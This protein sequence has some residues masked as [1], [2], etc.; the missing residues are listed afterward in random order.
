M[1]IFNIT[2]LCTLFTQRIDVFRWFL[3]ISSD[4]TLYGI[5]QV[6]FDGEAKCNMG[7]ELNLYI[8]LLF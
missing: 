3:K 1:A 2:K 8:G 6:V 5:N 7:L 4:Y